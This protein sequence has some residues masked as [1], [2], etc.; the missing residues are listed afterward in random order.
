MVGAEW[1]EDLGRW[2]VRVE[3]IQTGE[4]FEDSADVV[5]NCGGVLK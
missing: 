1:N 3:D 2:I 4:E 5:I